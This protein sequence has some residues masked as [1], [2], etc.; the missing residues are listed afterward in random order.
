MSLNAQIFQNVLYGERSSH[1]GDQ[2]NV[3]RI[4]IDKSGDVYP[5]TIIPDNSLKA[6]NSSIKEYYKNNVE[7]FKVASNDLGLNISE[8]T[9]NNYSQFQ[10]LLLKSKVE[11]INKNIDDKNVYFL[12]HGFRKPIAPKN[13]STSSKQDNEFLRKRIIKESGEIRSS[14]FIEIY[15]DGMY[16]CCVG[17]NLRTNKR[18]FK[19]YE[20]IAQINASKTGYALRKIIPEI[21]KDKIT[22]ITHSLG[23]QVAL[24]LLTNSFDE[25]INSDI[26]KLKTPEQQ[27]INVCLIAPAISKEPFYEYFE[28][29]SSID[30]ESKDNYELTILYNEKDFVLKKKWKFFGPGPKKYGNTS[31]GCNHKNEIKKLETYFENN[32]KNSYIKAYNTTI[33]KTHLVEH[34]ANSNNFGLYI[35]SIIK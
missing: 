28:R 14:Y 12:I 13:G 11:D 5:N 26:Q 27:K 18:I 7:L 17:K 23:S 8:F 29:T 35:G 3:Y 9:E 2:E 16:D 15:W 34:Y 20:N 30:F 19:L 25:R 22:V 32:F 33:G 31:L 6:N 24:S 4:F 1:F 10:K 21:D